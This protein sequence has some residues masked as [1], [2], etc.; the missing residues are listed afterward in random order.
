M[1]I[2]VA[3]TICLVLATGS[4]ANFLD[5]LKD[6]FSKLGSAVQTTFSAVGQ[7]AGVLGTQLLEQLK[8]QGGQLASLALNTMNAL[9]SPGGATK[10]NLDFNKLGEEAKQFVEHHMDMIQGILNAAVHKFQDIPNHMTA[11]SVQEIEHEIDTIVQ[12]HN[13]L[14]SQIGGDLVD[15]LVKRIEAAL[16]QMSHKRNGFTDALSSVGQSIANFFQPHLQTLQSNQETRLV[17]G[18]GDALKQ[19]VNT[20]NNATNPH[21]QAIQNSANELVHHGQNALTSVKEALASIM[22]NS[23]KIALMHNVHIQEKNS[24]IFDRSR[25][26]TTLINMAPHL[27]NIVQHGAQALGEVTTYPNIDGIL[28]KA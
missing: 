1:R 12:A 13:G 8:Q 17:S 5:S 26:K 23:M 4:Q 10:R 22:R 14:V 15:G 16:H 27:Q 28:S 6:T 25:T 3:L 2:A 9:Q 11:M 18:T 7:Q 24:V 19:T 21:H 20:F